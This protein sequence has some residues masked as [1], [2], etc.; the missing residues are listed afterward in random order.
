MEFSA[1]LLAG[2]KSSRM[3]T[4]KARLEIG[5]LPLW[6]WQLETL[7]ESGAGEVFVSGRRDDVF[8]EV[9]VLEDDVPD[10]GPLTGLIVSL[11]RAR[12]P[13]LLVLAVDLPGMT[14]EYLRRLV[15]LAQPGVGVVPKCGEFFEPVAALYPGEALASAEHCRSEGELSLQ[16]LARRLVNA[17]LVRSLDVAADEAGL[18]A[19]VNTPGDWARQLD[20]KSPRKSY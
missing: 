15:A 17:G 1:V 16:I 12:F 7:R 19:N 2:G 10:A 20:C 8:S 11:R 9:E 18:F 14:A 4:D 3:G 13:W 5:G 6:R